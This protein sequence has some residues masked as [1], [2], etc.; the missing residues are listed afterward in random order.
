MIVFILASKGDGIFKINSPSHLKNKRKKL[1]ILKSYNRFL[2]GE[3]E[4]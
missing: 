4:K 1:Y 3:F 2:L